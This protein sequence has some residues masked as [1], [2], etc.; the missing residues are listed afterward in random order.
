MVRKKT[1]WHFL[2][3]PELF[4][5]KKWQNYALEWPRTVSVALETVVRHVLQLTFFTTVLF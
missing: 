1:N 2:G 4:S 5:G 3:I